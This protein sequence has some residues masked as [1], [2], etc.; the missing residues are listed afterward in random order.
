MKASALLELTFLGRRGS[1]STREIDKMYS[2]P[3]G[4]KYF[5]GK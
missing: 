2:L 1:R 5:G 3:D 4:E